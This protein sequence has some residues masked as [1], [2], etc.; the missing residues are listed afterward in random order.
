[1]RESHRVL[2][3]ALVYARAGCHLRTSGHSTGR[4]GVTEDPDMMHGQEPKGRCKWPVSG[5]EPSISYY[6]GKTWIRANSLRGSQLTPVW[7]LS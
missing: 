1:M 7:E 5:A 3:E 2:E 6:C 4:E